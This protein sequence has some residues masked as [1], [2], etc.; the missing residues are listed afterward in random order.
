MLRRALPLTLAGILLA[1]G[2]T[3]TSDSDASAG[4]SD[5][6]TPAATVASSDTT[7]SSGAEPAAAPSGTAAPEA[8]GPSTA[9]ES[10]VVVPDALQISAPLVGGGEIELGALAGRPVLLWFWAPW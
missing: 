1:C 2:G 3:S 4:V 8:P 6:A 9:T 5:D 10:D 7:G